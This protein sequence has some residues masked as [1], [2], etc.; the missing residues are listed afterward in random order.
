VGVHDATGVSVKTAWEGS[1]PKQKKIATMQR[2]EEM[3]NGT[4]HPYDPRR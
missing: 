3:V 1:T 2:M 4:F